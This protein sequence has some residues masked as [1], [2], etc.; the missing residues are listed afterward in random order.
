[1]PGMWDHIKP[2]M[3]PQAATITLP[4]QTRRNEGTDQPR[5]HAYPSGS[6]VALC[7]KLKAKGEKARAIGFCRTCEGLA[8]S[9]NHR[10]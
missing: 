7:G 6:D 1:M 5:L 2:A 10:G 3:L 9:V 4:A 8:T